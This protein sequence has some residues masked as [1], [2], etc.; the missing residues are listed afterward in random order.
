MPSA[1]FEL[2]VQ[3]QLTVVAVRPAHAPDHAAAA[4]PCVALE[5]PVPVQSTVAAAPPVLAPAH[6][7]VA[8]LCAALER[9]VPAPSTVVG[10]LSGLSVQRGNLATA[11]LPTHPAA[12][13]CRRECVRQYCR[14]ARQRPAEPQSHRRPMQSQLSQ[15]PVFPCSRRLQF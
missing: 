5:L 10:V 11:I 12:T 14:R 4:A 6:A 2:P 9:Q 13:R 1:V 3:D 7:A 15:L 8:A